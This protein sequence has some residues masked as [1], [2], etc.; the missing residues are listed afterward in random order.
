MK[1]LQLLSFILIFFIAGCQSELDRDHVAM[2]DHTEVTRVAAS[3]S[4]SFEPSETA[5]KMIKEGRV[6]FRTDDISVT[7]QTIHAAMDEYDAY[8]SSDREQQRSDRVTATIV[9]RVPAEHFDRFLAS[10]TLGVGEFDSKE[11]DVR[12]VTEEFVDAGARLK[13]KRELETRYISL[14][15]RA[16]TVSEIV[17]VERQLGQVRAEIESIEGRLQYLRDRVQFSTLTLSFYKVQAVSSYTLS[18]IDGFKNGWGLFVEFLFILV[19]LWPFIL[20]IIGSVTGFKYYRK[21]KS[22]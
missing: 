21:R 17:E 13:T 2:P 9:I 8:I 11:I 15:D 12:D 3:A 7:R 18:F 5:V 22:T 16:N 20:M 10:A 14:L 1:K 6:H 19:N 4:D